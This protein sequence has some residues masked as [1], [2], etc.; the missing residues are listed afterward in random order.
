VGRAS[1]QWGG[2]PRPPTDM[3]GRDGRPTITLF[4]FTFRCVCEEMTVRM[5]L[6]RAVKSACTYKITASFKASR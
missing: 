6:R 2:R 4:F 3:A 1:A 5:K